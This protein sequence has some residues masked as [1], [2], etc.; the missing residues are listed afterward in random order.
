MAKQLEETSD[1]V[2]RQ[3][4][5]IKRLKDNEAQA[6]QQITKVERQHDLRS[7]EARRLEAEL[8]DLQEQLSAS[9]DAYAQI[10]VQTED[11]RE[12]Q[13][14]EISLLE[15]QVEHIEDQLE[16]LRAENRSYAA[17]EQ[18]LLKELRNMEAFNEKYKEKAIEASHR[19]RQL[20]SE[21]VKTERSAQRYIEEQVRELEQAKVDSLKG[22]AVNTRLEVLSDIKS[23]IRAHKNR[24]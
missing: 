24:I 7:E 19:A 12:Q 15:Q 1:L 9:R 5:E 8:I 14:K 21:V 16:R 6:R 2:T 20:E 23:M 10:E 3:E 17:R 18:E 22:K 4:V 13:S 11:L